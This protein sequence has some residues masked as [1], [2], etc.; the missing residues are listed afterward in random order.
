LDADPSMDLSALLPLVAPIISGHSDV[1]IG[2]RSKGPSRRPRGE[3]VSR[4]H[5]LLHFALGI[6]VE[7]VQAG[8]KAMRADVGCSTPSSWCGRSAQDF[9]S[10][11]WWSIGSRTPPVATS[12]SNPLP[13]VLDR[14][15]VPA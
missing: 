7:D 10:T 5:N 14:P 4:G 1:S 15:E 6:R 13:P 2:S 11:T 9:G 8:F 3:L 12:W